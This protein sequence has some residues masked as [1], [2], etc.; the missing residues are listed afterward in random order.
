MNATRLTI[1][2]AAAVAAV[3]GTTAAV[4]LADESRGRDDVLSQD[5]V[6]RDLADE[7]PP[8][9]TPSAM[10]ASPSPS[11]SPASP[12]GVAGDPVTLNRAAARLVVRCT[13]RGVWL[14]SWSP[15][16]GY[17]VDEVTRGTAPQVSVWLESDQFDDVEIIVRCEGG[18]PVVVEQVEP[19]DHG[20]DDEDGD[21]SGPD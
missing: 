20:D 21:N 10:A 17:R 12:P 1:W 11:S 5:E 9:T 8:A 2:A 7:T 16:P 18:E 6:A 19:D 4:A 14:A 3:G 13:E 15:N